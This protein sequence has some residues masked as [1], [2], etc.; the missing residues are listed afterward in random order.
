MYLPE[1][2]ST[3]KRSVEAI[4]Q[5]VKQQLTDP[6]IPFTHLSE[7]QHLD[8][9]KGHAIACLN[10]KHQP[11]YDVLRKAAT[12]LRDE[13]EFHVGFRDSKQ[14]INLPAGITMDNC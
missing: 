6:I 12:S 8:A 4:V 3:G 11:E 5:F 13:C 9:D 7:L 1:E 2:L 14:E 10:N